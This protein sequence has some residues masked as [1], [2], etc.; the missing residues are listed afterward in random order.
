MRPYREALRQ[1]LD[2]RIAANARYSMRAFA[3]DLD[4]SPSYLSQVLSGRRG[5]TRKKASRIFELIGLPPESQRHY[6][7]EIR[8]ESA[9]KDQHRQAI[10][11]QIA[12]SLQEIRAKTLPPEQFE[13]ISNWYPMALLQALHLKDAP[14]GERTAFVAFA[15]EGLGIPKRTI[16]RAM[17]EFAALGLVRETETGYEPLQA[18]VWTTNGVP[19][20]AIR[21]FHRQMIEKAVAA[22]ETQTTR[23][24]FLHS[25]QI[26]IREGDLAEMEK[27]VVRFRNA[28]L[29]KYGKTGERAGETIYG[30]NLQLFRL[31][32]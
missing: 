8:K 11:K 16:E 17:R 5:L 18:D 12:S 22:I 7:L 14:L 1:A 28:M 30:L 21:K 23:E 25:I 31:W 20:A 15:A 13:A 2:S 29:R 27:D 6:A 26:P 3:R 10:E 4:L 32:D 19:S 24:R 9:R